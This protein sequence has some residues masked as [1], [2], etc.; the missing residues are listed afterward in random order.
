[1]KVHSI[2]GAWSIEDNGATVT[3]IFQIFMEWGI[4]FSDQMAWNIKKSDTGEAAAIL[5]TP[6]CRDIYGKAFG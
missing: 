2:D 1:M 5:D 4:G 3:T 6:A